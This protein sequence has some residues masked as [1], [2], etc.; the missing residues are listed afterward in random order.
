[1]VRKFELKERTHDASLRASFG[2]G[3]SHTE[4]HC[5]TLLMQHV[6]QTCTREFFRNQKNTASRSCTQC[7][8]WWTHGET[9]ARNVARN[10]FK[11]GQT[12]QLSRC[13]QFCAQCCT[14]YPGR[15]S[16]FKVKST[17]CGPVI[18]FD[19]LTTIWYRTYFNVV[20]S[21]RFLC[22]CVCVCVCFGGGGVGVWLWVT[23]PPHWEYDFS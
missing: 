22:V 8:R 12:V 18:A 11:G 23:W 13:A 10:N 4:Q 15:N 5:V 19:T 16:A 9:V 2:T 6:T 14:V 17:K 3:D 1:M 20:H 21:Q 7:C